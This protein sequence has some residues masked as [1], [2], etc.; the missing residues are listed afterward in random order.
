ME[1]MGKCGLLMELGL[2][3]GRML[4]VVEKFGKR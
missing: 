4:Q 1:L 2:E 3:N